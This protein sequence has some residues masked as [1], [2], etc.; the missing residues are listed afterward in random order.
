MGQSAK[1]GSLCPTARLLQRGD[2]LLEQPEGDLLGF[3]G[4]LEQEE[5]GQ[6]LLV[7]ISG[8]ENSD[9][10]RRQPLQLAGVASLQEDHGEVEGNQ[11]GIQAEALVNEVIP[12]LSERG[13]RLVPLPISSEN[14]ALQPAQA[15]QGVALTELEVEAAAVGQGS[16][17][18]FMM[19]GLV[20]IPDEVV[21]SEH[22]EPGLL[23]D[24]DLGQT[25]PDQA[26][27][28]DAPVGN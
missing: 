22:Q 9:H 18:F 1:S 23:E 5:G 13:F 25:S 24:I 15:R 17:R 26:D 28:L 8:F 12:H 4:L 21:T 19:T 11:R 2:H 10:L 14:L 20:E 16:Q 27:R 7:I 3:S 6:R